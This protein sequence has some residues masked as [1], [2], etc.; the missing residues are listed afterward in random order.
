MSLKKLLL[1]LTIPLFLLNQTAYTQD[2]W[3]LTRCVQY[4]L[5]NNISVKQADI[6]ARIA[7]LTLDQS[8][9][10]Q[11]PTL[12]LGIGAGI[13]SGRF[14]NPTNFTLETQTS[15]QSNLG[16]QSNITVFNG[17]YLQRT[18]DA[19]RFAWQ[20]ALANTDKLK[21][22]ISLNVANAYLQVLLAAQTTA[23][24]LGQLRL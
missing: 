7:K 13:N 11:I 2:K 22:D 14:Q 17:F 4:A 15:L 18:I 3:D 23:A 9:L 20:A 21:N 19:N 10:S 1:F 8:K 16:L 12:T 6:Q 5:A 24:S